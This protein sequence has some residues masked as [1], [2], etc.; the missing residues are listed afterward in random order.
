MSLGL[1]LLVIALVLFVMAAFNV[2]SGSKINLT[3]LGLAT[4]VLSILVGFIQIG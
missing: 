1:L 3:S 4:C 2:P